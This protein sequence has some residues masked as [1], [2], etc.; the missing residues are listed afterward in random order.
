MSEHFTDFQHLEPEEQANIGLTFV[1]PVLFAETYL[2]DPRDQSRPLRLW[3]HQ[4]EDLRDRS[5]NI[6]HQDGREVGKSVNIFA[7]FLYTAITTPNG[8]G[9]VGTPHQGHLETL[10]DYIERQIFS[11]PLIFESVAKNRYGNPKISHKP[12][13]SI[14]FTNGYVGHFRPGGDKGDSFRSLHVDDIWI[15]EGAYLPERAWKAVRRCLNKGG[16]FR[17]YST[18]TGIRDHTYYRLTMDKSGLW[19]VVK[20]PSSMN[21]TYDEQQDEEYA[22]FYGGRDSAGYIHEVLGEHGKPSYA[23]FNIDHFYKCYKDLGPDAYKVVRITGEDLKGCAN[24]DEVAEQLDALLGLMPLTEDYD[25][26]KDGWSSN[27]SYWLGGDLGYTSDPA[28][29][30]IWEEL[31]N[32]RLLLRLRVHTEQVAYPYINHLIAI[33]D[34]YFHFAGL[35]IDRG[36]NGLSVY[37]DLVNLDKFREHQFHNRLQAFDFG[38]VTVVGT[39]PQ[40]KE[41]KKRTKELMT[42]LINQ[43]FT[44]R[45]ILIPEDN[46]LEDQIISQTYTMN[47]GKIVYSKGN[48]HINDSIRCMALVH[49]LEHMNEM[50]EN[51]EE[52][53]IVPMT[54][55]DIFDF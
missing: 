49:E 45:T 53:N 43:H 5:R 15:D 41:I 31:Q 32:G 11:S 24:E 16:R 4:K 9:L 19:H 22:E 54:T 7:D 47:L 38:S 20:W 12:Y 18:P 6:I 46:E 25:D 50:N 42:S 55:G 48:D 51:L 34:N 52:L 8:L 13:Y 2:K 40:G 21:P 33:L 44:R 3:D 26:F 29:L 28:E 17:I 23:A 39:T 1:D 37:Q 36:G 35:G 14:T 30:T 10:I 27:A